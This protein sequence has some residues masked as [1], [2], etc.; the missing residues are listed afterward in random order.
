[1]ASRTPG[2][3]RKNLFLPTLTLASWRLRQT[4]RMLLLTGLGTVAAVML[5][6]AVPLFSEIALSAGLRGVVA[7]D[8]LA[9]QLVVQNQ[10]LLTTAGQVE[11]VQEQVNRYV[12]HDLGSYAE[13]IPTFSI[14][15]DGL[16]VAS[17]S[18]SGPTTSAGSASSATTPL[19]L[20]G[21][22]SDAMAGHIS[23]LRG[24]A[25]RVNSKDIEI[26]LSESSATELHAG[27]GTIITVNPPQF[28][29]SSTGPG[30]A[31]PLLVTGIY[32]V[33]EK[34]DPI[35]ATGGGNFFAKL[36]EPYSGQS[37][38]MSAVASNQALL[39]LLSQVAAVLSGNGNNSYPGSPPFNWYYQLNIGQLTVNN[40]DDLN[41]RL[42]NFESDLFNNL[43][44][45]QGFQPAGPPSTLLGD[46]MAFKAEII[47]AQV[48]IVLLL[49]Q[50]LGLIL[51][52]IS[53]MIN[54]LVERQ[55]EAIAVLRSRGA[56]RGLIFRSM[57]V[58]TICI[59]LTALVVGPFLAFWL[60]DAF[61]GL[62]LGGQQNGAVAIILG[63]P[64]ATAWGLRWY[65]LATV[66]AAFVAMLISTHRA[67]NLNI[68]ALRRDSARSARQP[69]WQRL[70]LDIIFAI[71]ALAGYGFYSFAVS[72]VP[73]P[74]HIFLSALSLF[75]PIF[76]LL[77]ASLLFLRFFPALLQLG[78]KLASR[79]RSATPMLAI[80]QM[81]RAPRQA[82]RMTLLLALSTAFALFTLI[83]SASQYQ[84]TLDVSS[85]AV[86]SDFSGQLKVR[87]SPPSEISNRYQQIPGV[88]SVTLAYTDNVSLSNP[89]TSLNNIHIIAADTST[90]GRTVLW[91]NQEGSAPTKLANG[92]A[93]DRAQAIAH[94]VVPAV[95]DQAFAT[96]MQ[97]K[98]GGSFIVPPSGYGPDDGPMHFTVDAVVGNIPT[99]YDDADPSFNGND[100]GFL[101]DYQTFAAVYQHD[102]GGSAPQPNVVWLRTQGDSASLASVRA[103]LQSGPLAVDQ[104][105][106][107]RA[108]IDQ[109]QSN[110]LIIDLF[111]TLEMGAVTA[112]A[113]A[114]LGVLV[115]SWISA[116]NR[117]TSFALLRAIGTEPRQLT[118]VLLWEQGIVYSISILLGL[119]IGLILSVLVLPVLVIA[120]S[121]VNLSNFDT[122]RLNIPPVESIYPLPLMG[123]ALGLLVLLCLVA[124][125]LMTRI[126]ARAS[127]GQALRLNED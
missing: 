102:T 94:D 68:L 22:D 113:L 114:F 11:Q 33:Q 34:N 23:L 111:G 4:W 49:L 48:P 16:S 27:L 93:G 35:F 61:A 92:L 37:A 95:V 42:Q 62:A 9:G 105:Q 56:P 81:A 103:E 80:S 59:C 50:V 38:E 66:L 86:G 19:R 83:F 25:P 72:R 10:A 58:Q 53:L 118:R 18:G 75:A 14:N 13:A 88:T 123:L 30:L 89:I 109:T 17:V 76:L 91:P 64:L 110:P 104:M 67:A 41:Q 60:V 126:A 85:F 63:Q 100:G 124:I 54:L 51:L 46:L 125:L 71:I 40:M 3:R 47:I 122:S 127:I 2:R 21:I 15:L 69:F 5:V 32:T 106:D 43:S 1:M 6:S 108:L 8:P 112:L 57:T 52:F 31:I 74:L 115:A 99:L 36:S 77:A 96:G 121:I 44:S 82:S 101:V 78:A 98:A 84:R 119:I 90:Y 39:S 120:N 45:S 116:K 7:A 28:G 70:N 107:R 24:R 79:S 97:V 55:A 26:A 87:D 117:L 12:H 29:G 73:G 20:V 65:A